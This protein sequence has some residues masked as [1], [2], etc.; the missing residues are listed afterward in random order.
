MEDRPV[1]VYPPQPLPPPAPWPIYCTIT[2]NLEVPLKCRSKQARSSTRR[3]NRYLP[4]CQDRRARLEKILQRAHNDIQS[5][6]WKPSQHCGTGRW[7][8][9][10]QRHGNSTPS[11][12]CTRRTIIH[13]VPPQLGWHVD[14]ERTAALALHKNY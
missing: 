13:R 2:V 14:V 11:T 9:P 7:I 10:N 5:T 4:A 6:G 12:C 8:T 3:G 1:Q